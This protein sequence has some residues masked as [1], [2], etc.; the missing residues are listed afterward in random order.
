MINKNNW[1]VCDFETVT[2]ETQYFKT[3]NDTKVL[4]ADSL[5]WETN[6][7]NL[8]SSIEEW[9]DFHENMGVTQQLF[10]HNLS[11]DGTFILPFLSRKYKYN[12]S[13]EKKH[14]YDNSYETFR[15]GSRIYRIII[16]IRKKINGK[17]KRYKITICCSLRLL[18]ASIEALSKSYKRQK[19][20]EEDGADFY[21]I[22]PQDNVNNYSARFL[23]YIK[24][25]TEVALLSLKDFESA[26]HNLDQ[27]KSYNERCTRNGRKHFNTFNYLTAASLTRQI[28]CYYLR[29]HNDDIKESDR[30]LIIPN[31]TYVKIGNWFKGGVAQVN[32]KYADAPQKVD[33]AIMI[34]VTSAYPFQMTKDLPY[35]EILE[36][37]P[38]GSYVEFLEVDV[39]SAK[40]R[41]ESYEC[42]FLHNWKPTNKDVERFKKEQ[43]DFT[44]Y[45]IREEWELL[46]K[47]YNIEVNSIKSY[48]MKSSPFLKKYSKSLFDIKNHYAQIGHN[49]LKQ[50]AKILLNAGYGCLA[51]RDEFQSFLYFEKDLVKDL[52]GWDSLCKSSIFKYR[53]KEW[54]FNRFNDLFNFNKEKLSLV[55]AVQVED[56]ESKFNVNKAA[57]AVIT[58]RQRCY[59]YEKILEVGCEHF[60]LCDT[61]SILFG[62][63]T[64]ET[65]ER[66]I[67]EHSEELGG[68]TLEYTPHFFGTYGAKKY[69]MM[70]ENNE[71]LKLRFAGVTENVANLKDNLDFDA[72][73][74]DHLIIDDA[75][76]E[77][78]YCPSG[79]VLQK[80]PKEIKKGTF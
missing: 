65:Q 48:Y 79:I 78:K 11:F 73:T 44:C 24:N 7:H 63:I 62:N 35:G 25:D 28:M 72:F 58:A 47:F 70:D 15:Q 3:H 57:A 75:V 19:H 43:Y 4:L 45:Y 6:E 46:N 74:F 36:S 39:K 66:L 8:F 54:E 77:K 12:N 10:F 67:K 68:W 59:L 53:G 20:L 42:V 23:D 33:P 51:M 14:P 32:T 13:E 55:Q 17:W 69:V 50:A 38:Q 71:I 29:G 30:Y 60:L 5:C 31:S 27:I 26:V 22:E 9:W 49:G 61:D 76:F 37:P 56:K 18:N 64:K 34:D 80:R 52:E 21:N 2:P 41:P 1:F 40:L 16:F